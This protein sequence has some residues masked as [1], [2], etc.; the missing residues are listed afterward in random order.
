MEL[1]GKIYKIGQEQVVSDKFKKREFV[2][3]TDLDSQYP[4]FIAV[5]CTQDKCEL[6]DKFKVGQIV[7]AHINLRGRNWTNK[8][9]IEKTFNT[10][11]VWRIEADE[12]QQTEDAH[13][14][15]KEG[16]DLPF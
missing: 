16:N 12:E 2:L 8:E 14:E 6:L 5:E 10:L 3:E 4:Q 11:Q 9:G 13:V 7:T 15:D 1:K